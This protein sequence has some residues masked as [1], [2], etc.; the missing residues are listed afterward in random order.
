MPTGLSPKL[1]TV[2]VGANDIDF[3]DCLLSAIKKG[4]V[5]LQGATDPCSPAILTPDTKGPDAQHPGLRENLTNDLETLRAKY[6]SAP[7]DVMQY[8]NMF[9]P[10]PSTGAPLCAISEV[11]TITHLRAI[12]ISWPSIANLVILHHGTFTT[13]AENVQEDLYDAAQGVLTKI[14]EAIEEAAGKVSGTT[15]VPADFSGHDMCEHGEEWVFAPTAFATVKLLGA[16]AGLSYVGAQRCPDP[17][18]KAEHNYDVGATFRAGSV[19]AGVRLTNC[20]PH[21]TTAG[22]EVLANAFEAAYLGVTP[23]AQRAGAP[24]HRSRSVLRLAR[25][26]A[27][28]PR[29]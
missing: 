13:D 17:V 23:A 2:T 3:A 12:G 22:Q 6:P 8:Y 4:D 28:R 25:R 10:A 19:E 7:I 15:L 9:P 11:S 16:S 5:F 24:R 29:P 14:N 18:S 26:R 20:I 1:I 21:P 27:R